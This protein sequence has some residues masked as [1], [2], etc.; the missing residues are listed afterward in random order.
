MTEDNETPQVEETQESL[1][2]QIRLL[3]EK[4]AKKQH[5]ELVAES[6]AAKIEIPLADVTL[7]I[8]KNGSDITLKG[9]TP[10]EVLFLVAEHQANAG[11]NPI[12]KVKPTGKTVRVDPRV[13][14]ARLSAKYSSKK[15]EKLF[16]GTEPVFPKTFGRALT[17]GVGITLSEEKLLEFHVQ[18]ANNSA[19]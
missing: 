18:P 12:T 2:E 16:P 15:I 5:A 4:A 9:V 7:K 6:E 14:R 11:G 8:D 13:E 17:L 1:Q 10:G 19:D 3:Q